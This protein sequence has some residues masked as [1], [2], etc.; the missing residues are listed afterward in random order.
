MDLKLNLALQRHSHHKLDWPYQVSGLG[1]VALTDW[2]KTF[3][4]NEKV[5]SVGVYIC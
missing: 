5:L 1:Y 2:S 3:P 4:L